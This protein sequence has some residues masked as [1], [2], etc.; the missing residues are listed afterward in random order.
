MS[1]A[2]ASPV[3]DCDFP[4][5]KGRNFVTWKT[6]VTAAFDGKNLLD[7]VTQPNYAG[8][9]DVDLG[10]EDELDPSLAEQHDAPK[11]DL[12][13]DSSSGELSDGRSDG[14]AGDNGDV[15]MGQEKLP[16]HCT[17]AATNF[18]F[19]GNSKLDHTYPNSKNW[20]QTQGRNNSNSNGNGGNGR[21]D[22]NYG[23]LKHKHDGTGGKNRNPDQGKNRS[24]ESD[25]D[26]DDDDGAKCKVFRQQRRHTGIIAV[27]TTINHPISLT[28][29]AN[30]QL[31]PTWTIDAD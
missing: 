28:A 9:S 5:L 7:F 4:R 13:Q 3:N 27:A 6:R 16:L 14:S 31:D 17:K 15:E 30:V 12:Q 24:L 25:S 19:K 22:K 1:T 8:D 2:K 11:P 23:S 18:A 29:Q 21:R 26:D 10:Q 20:N